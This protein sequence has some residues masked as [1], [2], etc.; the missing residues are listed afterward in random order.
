MRLLWTLAFCL[1][2]SAGAVGAAALLLVVPKRGRQT[3]LPLLVSYATGSLLAAALLGLLPH[4]ME[5]AALTSVL[6]TVLVG[7]M[8]FSR[9]NAWCCG[10]TATSREPA[11]CT[12]PPGLSS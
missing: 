8:F 4:A 10:G 5:R 12:E 6:Q 9:W 7:L 11:R 1:L 2:G 3:L